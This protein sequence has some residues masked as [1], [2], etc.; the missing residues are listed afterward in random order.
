LIG[1]CRAS[2]CLSSAYSRASFWLL[3]DVRFTAGCCF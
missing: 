2:R 1:N 3:D